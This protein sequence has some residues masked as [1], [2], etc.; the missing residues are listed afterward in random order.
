MA[1]LVFCHGGQCCLDKAD[2][3]QQD[4]VK[5]NMLASHQVK[6][7]RTARA[8]LLVFE[9]L[10]HILETVMAACCCKKKKN[11]PLRGTGG[12]GQ[13]NSGNK[14]CPTDRKKKMDVFNNVKATLFEPYS[15]QR[16]S[17]S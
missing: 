16:L 15:S 14:V 8:S 7:D 12:M 17:D 1:V 10:Q 2:Y 9:D 5:N 6:V 13:T 4:F 11:M 3:L